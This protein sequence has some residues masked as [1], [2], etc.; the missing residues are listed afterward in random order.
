MAST[1]R[2]RSS[3]AEPL[4]VSQPTSVQLRPVTSKGRGVAAEHGWLQPS[5]SGFESWRPC[6]ADEALMAEHLVASEEDAGSNPAIRSRRSRSSAVERLR[7]GQEA[8]GSSPSAITLV[9]RRPR[10]FKGK[11]TSLSARRRRFEFRHGALD[12][13]RRSTCTAPSANGRPP[14]PQPGNRSSTLRGAITIGS[15]RSF[16]LASFALSCPPAAAGRP[17]SR[18]SA[19]PR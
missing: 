7:D 13:A 17:S 1:S 14:G 4:V 6:H 3:T 19:S 15:S 11:D 16:C 10:S 2:G 18:R 8:G 9:C 5:R 12:R